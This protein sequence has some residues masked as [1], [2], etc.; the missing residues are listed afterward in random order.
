MAQTP[1][2]EWNGN[3]APVQIVV[4]L[5][6]DE[7]FEANCASI[8]H[9]ASNACSLTLVMQLCFKWSTSLPVLKP[10][11]PNCYHPVALTSVVMKV[12][13]RLV[14]VLLC[15]SIRSSAGP[16]I[17]CLA[18][19]LFTKLRD[20]VV[21]SLG[22]YWTFSWTDSKLTVGNCVSVTISLNTGAL[23]GCVLSPLLYTLFVC[24]S[25]VTQSSNH[26][27]KLADVCWVL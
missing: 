5:F 26:I 9:L 14:K 8:N 16:S 2:T 22:G 12:F 21:S 7:H 24:D 6:I 19:K 17:V 4:S 20:L 15:S 3:N 25:V 1:I 10:S 11:S 13:E 27:V 18:L 23:Q